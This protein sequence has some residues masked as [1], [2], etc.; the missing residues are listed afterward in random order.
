MQIRSGKLAGIGSL[1][2]FEDQRACRGT[3]LIAETRTPL[4]EIKAST[5]VRAEEP[6]SLWFS[7]IAPGNRRCSVAMTFKPGS[8]KNYLVFANGSDLGCVLAI[9][10]ITDPSNPRFEPSHFARSVIVNGTPEASHCT[11]TDV[12]AQIAKARKPNLSQITMDDLKALLPATPE[13][14]K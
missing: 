10:D 1:S 6:A 11:A 9:E 8:G 14:A 3:R 4:N 12:D 13:Q 5:S 2:S 7:Y